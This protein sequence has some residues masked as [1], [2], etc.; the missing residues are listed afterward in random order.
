MPREIVI[1]GAR[2]GRIEVARGQVLE[3]VNVEGKQVC[4]FFAFNAGNVREALSPGHT[5]SVMRRIFL[6]PGDVLYSVLRRPMLELIEDTVGTNDFTLP[7]C[8][9]ERYRMDFKLEDH[10]SCRRNLEEAMRGHEIPYEYLPDPFNFF[11]PTPILPDGTY[12]WG[13]SPAKPGDRV[14][15]RA[16][17][18]VIAVGSSCPQDQIPLNDFKPSEL[19]LVVRDG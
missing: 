15:L 11:Q 10:R 19:K 12:G 13:T 5:R 18:D 14:V 6:R 1:P 4:D 8:D 9:P 17:M 3:V 2:G 16:L 7:P